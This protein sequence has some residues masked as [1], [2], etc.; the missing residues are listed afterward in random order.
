MENPKELN[1]QQLLEIL[2]SLT[3]YPTKTQILLKALSNFLKRNPP[4]NKNIVHSIIF[5][6]TQLLVRNFHCHSQSIIL[7]ELT[8]IRKLLQKWPQVQNTFVQC[9]GISVLVQLICSDT[10]HNQTTSTKINTQTKINIQTKT[11]PKT[12]TKTK[13]KKQSERLKYLCVLLL[14]GLCTSSQNK[15]ERQL[16]V[17][18]KSK[19][20]SKTFLKE[21]RKHSAKEGAIR[22]LMV[23][24]DPKQNKQRRPLKARIFQDIIHVIGLV[25]IGESKIDELL[26]ATQ[27]CFK[28]LFAS[29]SEINKKNRFGFQSNDFFKS[30]KK[31]TANQ[32]SENQNTISKQSTKS[33][34]NVNSQQNGI[35]NSDSGN[36]LENYCQNADS[37]KLMFITLGSLSRI[38]RRLSELGAIST[39][40]T[41]ISKLVKLTLKIMDQH[42]ENCF[43]QRSCCGILHWC[44]HS[45]KIVETA[46][47]NGGLERLFG[48]LSLFRDHERIIVASLTTLSTIFS[49]TRQLIY[50][51]VTQIGGIDILKKTSER[52]KNELVP[53]QKALCGVFAS[54]AIN[55]LTGNPLQIQKLLS[56]G[57]TT[58]IFAIKSFSQDLSLVASSVIALRNLSIINLDHLKR[59]YKD[60][61][62]PY[63]CEILDDDSNSLIDNNFNFNKN[64]NNTQDSNKSKA[65]THNHININNNING[66]KFVKKDKQENT[67]LSKL[68]K[69]SS[70]EKNYDSNKIELLSKIITSISGIINDNYSYKITKKKNSNTNS[71]N[72]HEEID[73]IQKKI[74]EQ[75]NLNQMFNLFCKHYNRYQGNNKNLIIAWFKLLYSL[76]SNGTNTNALQSKKIN[77]LEVIIIYLKR[78]ETDLVVQKVGLKLLPLLPPR[79]LQIN[80]YY[81]IK[82]IMNSMEIFPKNIIIQKNCCRILTLFTEN[83]Q[84]IKKYFNQFLVDL[85]ISAIFHLQNDVQISIYVLKFVFNINQ[86]FLNN[87]E[88]KTQNRNDYYYHVHTNN[89]DDD[90]D[91]DDN[92]GGGDDNDDDKNENKEYNVETYNYNEGKNL[93]QQ[94]SNHNEENEFNN[95]KINPIRCLGIDFLIKIFSKFSYNKEI[96]NLKKKYFKLEE[97]EIIKK[98]EKKIM[99]RESSNEN[100]NNSNQND[101]NNFQKNDKNDNSYNDILKELME[102]EDNIST[103]QKKKLFQKMQKS[104]KRQL[105]REKAK[106]ILIK[107]QKKFNLINFKKITLIKK[108]KMYNVNRYVLTSSHGDFH[109]SGTTINTS[110]QTQNLEYW[111]NNWRVV[112]LRIG[113]PINSA[114]KI[115]QRYLIRKSGYLNKQGEKVKN[116][117]RRFF[118][119]QDKSIS[120]FSKKQSLIGIKTIRIDSIL[121]VYRIPTKKY[122]KSNLFSIE[123]PNRIFILSAQSPNEV[124]EWISMI[125]YCLT[126]FSTVRNFTPILKSCLNGVFGS[127]ISGQELNVFIDLNGNNLIHHFIINSENE[128]LSKIYPLIET[129]LS[130]N[131]RNNLGYTPLEIAILKIFQNNNNNNQFN[132]DTN[133]VNNCNNQVNVYNSFYGGIGGGDYDGSG[134]SNISNLKKKDSKTYEL[135]LS[136]IAKK[137]I[138]DNLTIVSCLNLFWIN[139]QELLESEIFVKSFDNSSIYNFTNKQNIQKICRKYDNNL[140]YYINQLIPKNFSKSPSDLLAFFFE[141]KCSDYILLLLSGQIYDIKDL[142]FENITKSW[143]LLGLFDQI[144]NEL[145]SNNYWKMRNLFFK[146]LK[147]LTLLNFDFKILNNTIIENLLTRCFEKKK[148]NLILN[149]H[150]NL[151]NIY[152]GKLHLNIYQYL[153][154]NNDLKFLKILFN[155]HDDDDDQNINKK[156]IVE[157]DGKLLIEK[158]EGKGNK[159]EKVNGNDFFIDNEEENE[160]YFKETV[161]VPL[162]SIAAENNSLE[163]IKFLIKIG[164]DPNQVNEEGKTALHSLI[165]GKYGD[166]PFNNDNEKQINH[167]RIYLNH[168]NIENMNNNNSSG[169]SMGS[170][171]DLKNNYLMKPSNQ[172]SFCS[173]NTTN[174]LLS[175]NI[176]EEP[177]VNCF[178]IPEDRHK[179]PS[180]LL[181]AFEILYPLTDYNITDKYGRSLLSSACQHGEIKIVEKLLQNKKI[182]IFEYDAFNCS[183]LFY[184]ICF[185]KIEIVKLLLNEIIKR[186]LINK[187]QV[188]N[189]IWFTLS[190]NYLNLFQ[191]CLLYHNLEINNII[192]FLLI[193]FLKNR[194]DLTRLFEQSNHNSFSVI[195]I[196]SIQKNYN[197]LSHL[198]SNYPDQLNWDAKVNGKTPLM[199]LC[200]FN[201]INEKIIKQLI[202]IGADLSINSLEGT[203]YKILKQNYN[204]DLL[205][206]INPK[207][208]FEN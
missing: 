77:L 74:L 72:N 202:D 51:K 115:N 14:R 184:S 200:S 46:V 43:I 199:I 104:K 143:I 98:N 89:D 118:I 71:S 35:A 207:K 193:D 149:F 108:Q 92:G 179:E 55:P 101:L 128:Y 174:S 126:L 86:Y 164:K 122:N 48:N 111:K 157:N 121:S 52:S 146:I 80:V 63:I 190:K 49:N 19:Y 102:N 145:L 120:Y 148:F 180:E 41:L 112:N 56:F 144:F 16:K 22:A 38:F 194:I 110:T 23:Y 150:L 39:H 99:L 1:L 76:F 95:I 119:L 130:V 27:F 152:F 158:K 124:T 78:Y 47:K 206:I 153:I 8:I 59:V 161:S 183:P 21:N 84:I 113:S 203:A 67:K 37:F 57:I 117:K 7:L 62:I 196:A 75:I 33:Q 11:K 85:I 10:V 64:N 66:K 107:K 96:K 3:I 160:I 69:E 181:N 139:F 177:I 187:K 163:I 6:L 167:H 178:E 138:F 156:K 170:L 154:L 34:Q 31:K 97:F 93:K 182:K 91:D 25:S 186:E 94:K 147:N 60:K 79:K 197:V 54:L 20:L 169:G 28:I 83:H 173:M 58:S 26:D 165:S 100:Q 50:A 42:N 53:I 171:D 61:A 29:N 132:V 87:S 68:K 15:N 137:T 136:I 2:R 188:D 185:G 195:H 109:G 159:E 4:S 123:T 168:N 105:E 90:D 82:I 162:L 175:Y 44:C 204:G 131:H 176:T 191:A 12:K 125:K 151:I 103:K 198:L 81:I 134:G 24:A 73:K 70:K 142:C 40:E 141:I 116:W 106:Q 172:F 65:N 36:S 18:K 208:Y 114:P 189:E 201:E 192:F 135:F 32:N 140:F 9:Q 155:Y 5:Y 88:N 17:T 166:I 129:G 133:N 127:L 205:Q 30:H 45:K 13:S